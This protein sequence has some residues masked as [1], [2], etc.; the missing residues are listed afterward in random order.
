M[1][2]RLYVGLFSPKLQSCNW[3]S[4]DIICISSSPNTVVIMYTS[5]FN[6]EKIFIL[7]TDCRNGFYM[8]PRMNRDYNLN[9]VVCVFDLQCL[10]CEVYTEFLTITGLNFRLQTVY[11]VAIFWVLGALYSHHTILQLLSAEF[12]WKILH[13]TLP[14]FSVTNIPIFRPYIK[15]WLLFH[16]NILWWSAMLNIT[17]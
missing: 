4:M 6:I 8:I 3:Y 12:P 13:F 7:P 2:S 1:F 9:W 10:Y 5:S 15:H 17:A 16:I 14:F 11:T